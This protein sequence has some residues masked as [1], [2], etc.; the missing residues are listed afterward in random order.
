MNRMGFCCKDGFF[1]KMNGVGAAKKK[2]EIFIFERLSQ[3]NMQQGFRYRTAC[4]KVARL[5]KM[6]QM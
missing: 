2:G 3:R 5:M 4:N 1:S 6:W